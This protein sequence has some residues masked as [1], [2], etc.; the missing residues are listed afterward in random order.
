MPYASLVDTHNIIVNAIRD[1]VAAAACVTVGDCALPDVDD[2]DP[3]GLAFYIYALLET[4]YSNQEL[5]SFID[6][7]H[8]WVEEKVD[9][10]S[11]SP[12]TD[13]D[14]A[15]IGLSIFA[16]CKHRTCPDVNGKITPLTDKYF[17]D[18]RG[19]F[20]N[21]LATVLV[22]LGLGKLPAET[23]L[24]NKFAAYINSELKDHAEVIFND[25]KNVIVAYIWAKETQ[26]ESF[27]HKIRQACLNGA[28]R[29][30]LLPRDLV[31]FTH[32]LFEEIE[33]LTHK[34]KLKVKEYVEE[35]L[36]FIQTYSIEAG[37]SRD[38]LEEFRDDI[39]LT[40]PDVMRQYGYV[41][42]PRLSR[43]LLAVGHLIEQR[44]ALKPYLLLSA[45]Q[46]RKQWIRATVYS[47]SLIFCTALIIYLGI[48][49]GFPFDGKRD[50]AT[51]SFFPIL[52]A[53]FKL[54]ANTVWIVII[55][56][57]PIAAIIVGYR[58]LTAKD[59]DDFEALKTA[60]ERVKSIL[61]GDVIAATIISL[62]ITFTDIPK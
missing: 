2:H 59:M 46:K 3:L 42:R 8:Y 57:L 37:F 21:F 23:P 22:G 49:I 33:N 32:V 19:L 9:E 51:K 45:Q 5:A 38:I 10:G 43:I 53:I 12:Y 13:R 26:A 17:S 47:I 34:Q 52:G 36:R 39:A 50:I 1:D 11:V 44:Y 56:T 62:F 41:A 35:S 24:Y 55:T 25:A 28:A 29:E 54:L 4:G 58:L 18:S 6:S 27:L 31:Y 60:W 7:W 14:L 40:T 30:D 15:A 16:L 61:L 48:N 20:N